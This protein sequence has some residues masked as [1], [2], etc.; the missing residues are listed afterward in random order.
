[1]Y[2]YDDGDV[3]EKAMRQD[4]GRWS[5]WA[6]GLAVFGLAF[7]IIQAGKL[8]TLEAR[9][10]TLE[11]QVRDSTGEAVERHQWVVRALTDAGLVATAPVLAVEA[12]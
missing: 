5:L 10:A 8:A 4:V 6:I 12:Q 7:G 2:V 3:G 11:R 9:H 1:M